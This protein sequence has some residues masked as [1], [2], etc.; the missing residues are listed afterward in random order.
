MFAHEARWIFLFFSNA[1]LKRLTSSLLIWSKPFASA[2]QQFIHPQCLLLWLLLNWD[3]YCYIFVASWTQHSFCFFFAST[4]PVL[5]QRS[6]PA[7]GLADD[8][9]GKGVGNGLR[10]YHTSHAMAGLLLL[11]SSASEGRKCVHSKLKHLFGSSISYSL[12]YTGSSFLASISIVGN[13]T[14]QALNWRSGIADNSTC[15][16]SIIL[17]GRSVHL[18]SRGTKFLLCIDTMSTEYV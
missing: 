10:I 7:M 16:D 8:D 11:V 18:R 5:L 3:Y 13:R 6:R 9:N 12:K 14:S 15:C 17:I 1:F 4:I 2:S